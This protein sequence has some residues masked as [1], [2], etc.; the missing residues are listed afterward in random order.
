MPRGQIGKLDFPAGNER[1]RLLEDSEPIDSPGV[2]SSRR[3]G[4][5]FEQVA[6]GIQERDRARLK[7]ELTKS[8]SFVWA[9]IS[10]YELCLVAT[11][12]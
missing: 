6:Q 2:E 10:W 3:S 1:T 11:C 12:D 8:I 7:R 9:I 4:Y 5:F